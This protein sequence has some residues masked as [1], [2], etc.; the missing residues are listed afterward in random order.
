MIKVAIIGA[1]GYTA[2]ES[3][4]I[5]LRH[6]LAEI[7]YLTA[8]P[9]ECAPVTDIFPSLR[10]RIDLPME[11]LDMD[12]L[13]NKADVALCCL[14]H[15]VS[16]GFVPRLLAAGLKVIDFSAD[17]RLHDPDLYQRVYM[18]H[19]TDRD[20]ISEA[21]FGLPELFRSAIKSARLVANPGCYPTAAALALAPLLKEQLIA[22]DDIVV[23]AIS[24]VTGAGR[25]AAL[26]FHFPEMNENIFGYAV[27]EHRHMP[28]IEQILTDFTG[29]KTKVLFQPHVAGFDR[30]IYESVYCHPL[31]KIS[32]DMLLQLYHDFYAGEPFVRVLAKP[33]AVKDV[34]FTNFC[35]IFPT[36]ARGKMMVFSAIDNLIKGAA[37]QAVQNMNLICGFEETMGLL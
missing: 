30:G 37:G 11:P 17:Y 6:S 27:G 12:I 36:Q 35:D 18:T 22:C 1:T 24:G 10:G 8:L 15:R 4:E 3:I 23:N 34:A 33:P 28:E 29:R 19:H 26:A 20:T 14:P 31:E 21:A 13:T 25:K 5:L 7:T 16:M 9:D 2:R 32:D